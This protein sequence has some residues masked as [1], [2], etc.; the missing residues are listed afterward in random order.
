MEKAPASKAMGFAGLITAMVVGSL[1]SPTFKT[2]LKLGITPWEWPC[3]GWCLPWLCCW[4][5]A[6]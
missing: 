3:G 4:W 5:F 2:A 6:G 1:M